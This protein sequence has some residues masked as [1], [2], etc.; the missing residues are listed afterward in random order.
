MTDYLPYTTG[1]Y[2][3]DAPA[4]AL[5]FERWF[6]NWEAGFEGA[7]GAPRLLDAALGTTVTAA[8]IDWVAKRILAMTQGAIGTYLLAGAAGGA[9]AVAFGATVAGSA[10]TP[11]GLANDAGSP[12]TM[13][14]SGGARSGTWRCMGNYPGSSGGAAARSVSLFLRIA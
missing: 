2:A 14:A 12:I 8:G 5:H 4:T 3:V 13:T 11:A 7:A 6:R 9:T 1:E 10:L